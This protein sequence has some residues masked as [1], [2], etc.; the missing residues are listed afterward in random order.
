MALAG[1]LYRR[2]L[3]P[4]GASFAALPHHHGT[5][6]ET[7][8]LAR[9]CHHPLL[10]EMLR[11]ARGA[12]L[13]ARHVA[14]LLELAELPRRIVALSENA[15]RST[16]AAAPFAGM[17]LVESARGLLAH[18]AACDVAGNVRVWRALAPTEWNFHPEGV[19]REALCDAAVRFHDAPAQ[20]RKLAEDIVQALDPCVHSR[21]TVA[22]V[23]ADAEGA[24]AQAAGG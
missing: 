21:V 12:G 2:L 13:L 6:C 19:L 16:Q 23:V 5:P 4:D 20:L 1:W 11:R 3:E 24:V 17:G 7:G 14:R 10:A 8:A 9:Q 22:P 18:A 15:G